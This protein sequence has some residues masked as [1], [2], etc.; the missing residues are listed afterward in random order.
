MQSQHLIALKLKQEEVEEHKKKVE[1]DA[2]L[3][4]DFKE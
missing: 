4:N 3:S 1:L 2:S